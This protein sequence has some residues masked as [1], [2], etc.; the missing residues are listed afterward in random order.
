MHIF[1]QAVQISNLNKLH[2]IKTENNLA[3]ISTFNCEV[4][5]EEI[6]DMKLFW[7]NI[8]ITAFMMIGLA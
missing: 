2:I 4:T 6:R 3:Q 1:Q 7:E 5:L 8:H